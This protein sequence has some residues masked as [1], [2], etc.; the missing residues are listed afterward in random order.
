MKGPRKGTNFRVKKTE[1]S[2][3]LKAERDR[4]MQEGGE[5]EIQG[6]FKK[7]SGLKV[8]DNLLNQTEILM[9]DLNELY[10]KLMD[11]RAKIREDRLVGGTGDYNLKSYAADLNKAKKL[12][13]SLNYLQDLIRKH[14][15]KIYGDVSSDVWSIVVNQGIA[16]DGSSDR[17]MFA[18]A[19]Y[20][21]DQKGITEAIISGNL[22]GLRWLADPPRYVLPDQNNINIAQ[23]SGQWEI[24]DWLVA[25][26]YNKRPNDD[27]I[28]A[29]PGITIY[30]DIEY[31]HHYNIEKK[32]GQGAFG[33]VYK[34]IDPNGKVV[35]LKFVDPDK[36]TASDLEQEVGLLAELSK[37][38]CQKNI[39]CY[40]GMFDAGFLGK[41]FQVISMEYIDGTELDKAFSGVGPE[42]TPT[43][44][45]PLPV[46]VAR[47]IT[48]GLLDGLKFLHDRHIYH[49]DIKGANILLAKNT[50]TPIYV[51][52]GIGCKTDVTKVLYA[53]DTASTG[54]TR[55]YMSKARVDCMKT[56]CTEKEYRNADIW[57]L[58]IVLFVVLGGKELPLEAAYGPGRYDVIAN[59]IAKNGDNL[60]PL[61]R[62][63]NDII[64][65]ALSGDLS[66]T[67]DDLLAILDRP[68]GASGKPQVAPKTQPQQKAQVQQV[69]QA[70]QAPAMFIPQ[71]ATPYYKSDTFCDNLT[72]TPAK[73][74]PDWYEDKPQNETF[75]NAQ[76][77]YMVSLIDP[78]IT[79]TTEEAKLC[80][81]LLKYTP[82]AEWIYNQTMYYKKLD[83]L[84]QRIV[85]DYQ[86]A[87]Y[88]VI[89]LYLRGD[90]DGALEYLSKPNYTSNFQLVFS[91]KLSKKDLTPSGK[92]HM[93]KGQTISDMAYKSLSTEFWQ[94]DSL[95]K[96]IEYIADRFNKII[97]GAPKLDKDI[98][99]YRGV[100]KKLDLPMGVWTSTKGFLSTTIDFAIALYFAGKGD[101][102]YVFNILVPKGSPCLYVNSAD[103]ASDMGKSYLDRELEILFPNDTQ[104]LTESCFK[105]PLVNFL[106]YSSDKSGTLKCEKVKDKITICKTKLQYTGK[107]VPPAQAPAQAPAKIP[108][109]APAQAKVPAQA[110]A[111]AQAPA[112]APAP[113]PAKVPAPAPAK[114]PAPAAVKAPAQAAAPAPAPAAA[115]P[116]PAPAPAAAA[117]VLA[118]APAQ[119]LQQAA[120]V[121]VQGKKP[122][123]HDLYKKDITKCDKGPAAGGYDMPTLK[124]IANQIG[125]PTEG[126]LKRDI[127]QDLKALW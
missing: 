95:I 2:Y 77:K 88:R 84:D 6:P 29:P 104:L 15:K 35:A 101:E 19:G 94:R 109:Q 56:L 59:Y 63:L 25:P 98:I 127:C 51:D 93:T 4:E 96:I 90:I 30:P 116:A 32:L 48:K 47:P 74:Y 112:P 100:D 49:L 82:D 61:D 115:P 53:C 40:H 20:L 10:V 43:R 46:E 67:V 78:T 72:L 8:D 124:M 18:L 12:Q 70:Q 37:N 105:E 113:A 44:V 99:V 13:T 3:L 108:A 24:L 97:I 89:N 26:P 91:R 71:L 118:K 62:N 73:C 76:L 119:A 55:Y 21:P 120:Q 65:T 5:I 54:G 45:G 69:Q 80:D 33:A 114:V 14:I 122:T 123:I 126:R 27:K 106:G 22:P 125:I 86:G 16:N 39:V 110:Q 36:S 17:R 68:V 111:Q 1:K 66:V 7:E 38:G 28:V 92:A 121:P 102:T 41:P 79:F 64:R 103:R 81:I 50:L 83:E 85:R 75:M 52:F 9:I 23:M 42:G 58:G 34:A 60:Y 57:A 31:F 117:A 107:T 11:D 87:G